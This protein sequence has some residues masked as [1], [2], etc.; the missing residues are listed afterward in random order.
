VTRHG[1]P[2]LQPRF[3]RGQRWLNIALRSLHILGVVGMGAGFLTRQPPDDNFRLYLVMTL[4]TG[5]GMT[6]VDAWSNRQWLAQLSGQTVL[7]KLLLLGL[8]PLW[9]DAREV[10]F[11]TVILISAVVSH[12]PARIRHKHIFPL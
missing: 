12:A 9:P 2:D 1:Q 4:A 8:I 3:F 7:L 5:L 11:V 6:L 10:L